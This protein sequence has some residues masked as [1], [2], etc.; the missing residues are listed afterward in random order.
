MTVDSF[1]ENLFIFTDFVK[2]TMVLEYA[3]MNSLDSRL[4]FFPM[5]RTEEIRP[6]IKGIVKEIIYHDIYANVFEDWKED[7]PELY[8]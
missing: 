2:P 8:E 4:L 5:V 7:T 1:D 6:S 3:T